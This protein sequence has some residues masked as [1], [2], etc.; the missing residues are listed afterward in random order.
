M[1]A[2]TSTPE[3]THCPPS[4]GSLL[5]RIEGGE[6]EAATQLY[7][8]YAK[9]LI[10]LARANTSRDLAV[11]FDPEDVVQSVFRSFFRRANSGYYDVPESGDLWRLLLVLA[12]N[13][14]RRLAVHHRADKRNVKHTVSTEHLESLPD[15][16][17]G[18]D[19]EAVRILELVVQEILAEMTP[20]QRQIIELRIEGHSIPVIAASARRSKRTVERILKNFREQISDLIA[21]GSEAD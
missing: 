21:D 15:S 6:S 2:S 14:V 8:R 13:K 12:L 18:E 9:R 20:S 5:R 19:P 1:R 4:D 3:Q 16:S 10:S 11:R 17:A 7:L